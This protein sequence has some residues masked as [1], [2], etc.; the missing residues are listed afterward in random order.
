M[1]VRKGYVDWKPPK[2]SVTDNPHHTGHPHAGRLLESDTPD[3]TGTRANV[4]TF[5]P[6]SRTYWH[7]H[8][9]GQ[10][11]YIISGEGRVASETGEKVKVKI[12]DIIHT[13]AGE[14]HWHGAGPDTAMAH[15]A[16]ATGGYE[17]FEEVSEEEYLEGFDD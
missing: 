1:R 8:D 11:L 2:G 15:L 10:I 14:R 4:L 16:I 17:W 13:P 7:R 5:M 9:Q 6:G 3:G 12:G